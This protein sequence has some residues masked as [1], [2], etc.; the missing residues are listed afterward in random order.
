MEKTVY[1]L[2]VSMAEAMI[3]AEPQLTELDSAIGDGDC[4]QG[5]KAGFTAVL[6]A[7]KEQD[8]VQE[9]LK[10][11]AMAMISAIGGTSGAIY[12]TAFMKLGATVSKAE[13]ITPEV[14]CE[15]LINA[16]EGAKMRGEGTV[17]GD[18]T[19]IDALEP[20]VYAFKD[21]ILNGDDYAAAVTKAR[22]AAETGSESTIQLIAKKGRASYLGER[23]IGHRDAGSYG[24]V[25]LCQAAEKYLNS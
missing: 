10:K 19:L 22:K 24:I 3:E 18:K 5:M 16:L 21:A 11:T 20:A 17:V 15:A 23:S 2:L 8:N 12:G 13:Q 6:D 14:V 1:G 9:L 7:I 25:V 4:G